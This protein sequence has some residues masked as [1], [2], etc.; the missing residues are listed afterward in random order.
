M[1]F[2]EKISRYTLG[3]L[4]TKDCSD[5][6]LTGLNE[7]LD[8]ENMRILAGLDKNENP[9]SA[10][11]YLKKAMDDFGIKIPDR[12]KALLN[13]ITYSADRIINDKCDAFDGV[14]ELHKIINETEFNWDHFDFWEVYAV[15]DV[16]AETINDGLEFYDK[17]KQTKDDFITQ[18]K[19]KL[20]SRLVEWRR[21]QTA[22]NSVHVP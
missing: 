16:I 13:I 4:T 8:S 9:F 7:G 11:S 20:K 17:Q 12:K 3:L 21:K 18:E 22:Y 14:T 1:E 5:I 6:G 19:K 2:R 15:Y 10:D